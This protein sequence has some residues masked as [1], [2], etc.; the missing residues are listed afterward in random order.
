MRNK[1]GKNLNLN[2]IYLNKRDSELY[3]ENSNMSYFNQMSGS[4]QGGLGGGAG[5]NQNLGGIGFNRP[6]IEDN[7]G[8]NPGL[9]LGQQPN[10]YGGVNM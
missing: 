7:W 6:R 9:G 8:T 5:Y 4:Y 1:E 3:L 2:I 10:N